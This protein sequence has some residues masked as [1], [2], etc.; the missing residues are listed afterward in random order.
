MAVAP[1][2]VWLGEKVP[3]GDP[4]LP[5]LPHVT[6]QS[7]PALAGSLPTEAETKALLPVTMGLGGACVIA[8]EMS[9]VWGVAFAWLVLHPVPTPTVAKLQMSA[10]NALIPSFQKPFRSVRLSCAGTLATKPVRANNCQS[11]SL[12]CGSFIGDS[13]PFMKWFNSPWADQLGLGPSGCRS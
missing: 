8:T 9:G 3:H 7:T 1:L 2:A 13:M 10:T 11:R 6:T 4:L 12:R 5:A